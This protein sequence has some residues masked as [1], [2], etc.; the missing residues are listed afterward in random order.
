MQLIEV[1]GMKKKIST[2]SIQIPKKPKFLN[3]FGQ[4]T[5]GIKKETHSKKGCRQIRRQSKLMALFSS[6][7]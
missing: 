4:L 2:K 3:F 6:R 7:N 1:F 5:I